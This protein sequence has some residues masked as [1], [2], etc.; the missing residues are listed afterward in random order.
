MWNINPYLLPRIRSYSDAL[1]HW[2]Q[3]PL[4]PANGNW[5]A[6]CRKRDTSKL[7]RKDINGA[8]CLRYHHT[9][10][11]TYHDDKTITVSC[12]DSSNTIAFANQLLP[13]GISAHTSSG[14][15]YVSDSDGSYLPVAH[16]DLKFNK[17]EHGNWKV[18][19]STVRELTECKLDLKAAARIR[20]ILRP[21][22]DWQ[23]SVRRVGGA[24]SDRIN[25]VKLI[26]A[27]K[28][29][30]DEGCIPDHMYATLGLH[31][32]YMPEAYIL[33]GAVKKITTPFG[34]K[35]KK[36]IYDSSVAWQYV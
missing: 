7:I 36:T 27:L 2:E 23:E 26:H 24:H 10:V 3:A 15:M 29:C 20:K 25:F 17:D 16:T 33:G 14:I 1:K 13:C 22:Q 11:V 21:F 5:R 28:S 19:P 34:W 4:S 35:E 9:D 32:I 6:L 18:N 12:Y 31:Y 30:L 8:I